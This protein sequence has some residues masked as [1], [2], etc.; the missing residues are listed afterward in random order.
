MRLRR[1]SC[2]SGRQC[3]PC[4]QGRCDRR[5][6]LGRSAAATDHL[7]SG[8]LLTK[9]RRNTRFRSLQRIYPGG[10][11]NMFQDT[12]GHLARRCIHF[13]TCKCHSLVGTLFQRLLGHCTRRPSECSSLG[14]KLCVLPVIFQD[15]CPLTDLKASVGQYTIQLAKLEGLTVITTC[16][17]KNSDLARTLGAD[18]V[19]DYR[20]S[21]VVDQIKSVAPDLKYVFDTIGSKDSSEISSQAITG[22]GVLCTVRPGKANTEKVASNV[23]ITDVLVWKSFLKEHRFGKFHWPV[24][25]TF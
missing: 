6:N 22:N 2:G 17:P 18:H 15:C 10:R 5:S 3:Q 8:D 12:P 7:S 1:R 16:S 25:R 23:K 13:A 24:R 14:W 19:F 21:N 9:D 11:E 4:E 20:S